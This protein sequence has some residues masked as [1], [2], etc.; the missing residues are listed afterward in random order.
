MGTLRSSVRRSYQLQALIWIW[1][2]IFFV[3]NCGIPR[4]SMVRTEAA[5]FSGTNFTGHVYNTVSL[6]LP[7]SLNS[8]PIN[9]LHSLVWG[10]E[11]TATVCFLS[12]TF[13]S[14][15][16]SWPTAIRLACVAF[17][18]NEI[19]IFII[20]IN[21]ACGYYRCSRR[22]FT[23]CIVFKGRV[24]ICSNMISM[25]EYWETHHIKIN[26]ISSDAA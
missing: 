14:C 7:E 21:D 25:L 5:P 15:I 20:Q 10:S 22:L 24:F 23:I 9:P 6:S 1:E 19:I 11:I 16:P 12:L 17:F 3:K 26:H 18:Y 4:A 8:S 13:S 2:S